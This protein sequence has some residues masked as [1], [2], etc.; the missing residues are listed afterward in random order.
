MKA[1][2]RNFRENKSGQLLI[3]AALAIAMLIASAS[4]YVYELNVEQNGQSYY[5]IANFVPVI[6]QCT[7]NA[8]ISSLAN[9]SNGG[10]KTVLA[11]NLERLAGTI[12]GLRHQAIFQLTFSLYN[13][14]DYESGVRLLWGAENFGL[15]SAYASFTLNVQG[16]ENVELD[17]TINVTTAIL[18]EGFY[19]GDGSEKNVTVMCHIY[20]EGKPAQAKNINLF[21]EVG[22]AWVPVDSLNNILMVDFENGTYAISFSATIPSDVVRVSTHI[23]DM[24]DILVY[25]NAT[26]TNA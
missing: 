10:A 5:Q 24:R 7:K 22:D 15:S 8:L 23:T 19:T 11:T 1:H 17:Y 3:V 12:R 2:R 26:C 16:I 6:K 14:S 9:V 13:N 25:A 20:N 4:I 21:Y 18:V